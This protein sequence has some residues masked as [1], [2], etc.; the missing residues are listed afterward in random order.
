MGSAPS[1]KKKSK[2]AIY[3]AAFLLLVV[4]GIGLF[5]LLKPSNDKET[6]IANND[7]LANSAINQPDK[8]VS[9]SASIAKVAD[10]N[11]KVA[12]KQE[13]ANPS[14]GKESASK[15]YVVQKGDCLWKI[16]ERIYQDPFQWKKIYDKNAA[17]I[18]DPNLIYPEQSLD[19]H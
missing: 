2:N 10:S 5:F 18:K 3:I 7:T 15:T 6:L 1:P 14:T 19:L 11:N 16:A 12:T 13:V 9:D 4:L 8:N 17:I